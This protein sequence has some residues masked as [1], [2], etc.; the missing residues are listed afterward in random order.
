[1][2]RTELIAR[3]EALEAALYGAAESLA[4]FRPG[5]SASN[6]WTEL[7]EVTLYDAQRLC[8]KYPQSETKAEP[9]HMTADERERMD[10]ALARSQTEVTSEK[11][12]RR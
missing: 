1:M 6:I 4:S 7:D 8:G 9:R 2:N 3:C 5:A 10:R 12:E 11:I